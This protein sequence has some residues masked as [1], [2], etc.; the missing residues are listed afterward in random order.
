MMLK[1]YLMALTLLSLTASAYGSVSVQRGVNPIRHFRLTCQVND[2]QA[3]LHGTDCA[4]VGGDFAACN[5]ATL[6]LTN[7]GP[8]LT[9][10]H[11]ALYL[12]NVHQRLRVEHDQFRMTHLVGGLTRLEPT[13]KFTGL[14]AGES[15]QVPVVREY[16]Q[17]FAHKR[18]D[19]AEDRLL[20]S[21]RSRNDDQGRQNPALLP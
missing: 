11:W 15:V 18:P 8:A 20:A 17:S 1:R 14:G 19:R 2:N 3:A 21:L 12:S 4:A 7:N 9:D 16:R 5:R 10:R 6:T 13:E